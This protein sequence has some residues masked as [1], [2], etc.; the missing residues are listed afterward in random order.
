[1]SVH[2]I[3]A[4]VP[5]NGR[6]RI[7]LTKQP[8]LERM[9]G[10]LRYDEEGRLRLVPNISKGDYENLFSSRRD[11]LVYE[12]SE[13]TGEKVVVDL[14]EIPLVEAGQFYNVQSDKTKS[15]FI[16]DDLLEPDGSKVTLCVYR[17]DIA[18]RSS[19]LKSSS[20]VSREARLPELCEWEGS[21][22]CFNEAKAAGF[23]D[24]IAVT[25]LGSKRKETGAGCLER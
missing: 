19:A 24:E 4:R 12:E 21:T 20:G 8:P 1:M 11:R 17:N 22:E 5:A 25:V 7:T 16:R 2:G 23:P 10:G 18:I 3:G 6:K 15:H 14:A 9:L 13:L